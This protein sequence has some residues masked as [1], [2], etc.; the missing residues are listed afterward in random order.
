MEI[1]FLEIR[2]KGLIELQ[3]LSL[4]G[5]STKRGDN[6]MIGQFGSGLKYSIA[7]IL[8]Q[9]LP[10]LIFSG[11]DEIKVGRKEVEFGGKKFNQIE[12]NG[13]PTSLT[14][15]MGTEDW[16][17][18]WPFI[19]EIYS[20]ALDEDE[21]AKLSIVDEVRPTPGYTT[22]YIQ[23]NED[24][25]KVYN[26]FSEYFANGTEALFTHKDFKIYNPTEN[27]IIFRHGIRAWIGKKTSKSIFNYDL[28]DV[29]INESRVVANIYTA[30]NQIA[31]ILEKTTD[32]RVL[33][34]WIQ[35]VAGANTGLLEHECVRYSWCSTFNNP[36]LMEVI[37]E[38]KYYPIEIREML[39]DE[40]KKGRLAL[41]GDLLKRFLNYAPDMDCIGLGENNKDTDKIT[42]DATPSV[43]LVDKVSDA[44]SM[45][46]KTPYKNRLNAEINYVRFSGKSVLGQAKD[47]EI[48][49]SIKLDTY[50][51][52]E[53]ATIIIE[54][55]EHLIT[56]LNDET[57]EFQNHLFRL[58]FNE[59]KRNA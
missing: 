2:S 23:A 59:L 31:D 9:E 45:L 37:L 13:E 6:S 15:S 32:K 7:S 34:R 16:V 50:S 43:E 29:Q 42:I 21:S 49:L 10:F 39:E 56:D 48:L 3:A 30:H 12:F 57:R 4:I 54:E 38:F 41:Q 46:N 11:T 44:V 5:A 36:E 25:L 24:I 58:Y 28:N 53:I 33:R 26:S 18:A 19:R 1:K 52:D 14:D 51:V 20:N 55:Q 8:R 27:P 40:E 35:G 17:G 47:G 22:Y